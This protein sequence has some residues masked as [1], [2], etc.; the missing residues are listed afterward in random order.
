M[1]GS[2]HLGVS[3]SLT[4]RLTG[5]ANRGAHP[6]LKATVKVP[7][8]NAD[9]RRAVVTLPRSEILDQGHIGTTCTR[10][11][12]AAQACPA[13]SKYGFAKAK[14]PL[15]D[16][17]LE[18]PVYLRAS[19]HKLPD[20]VA[21]L[22]GQIRIALDGKIE[23]VNGAIRTIFETVPDAPITSFVLNMQGG[24]KGLLQNTTNIC[25]GVNR[26]KAKFSAQNGRQVSLNPP[27]KNTS[28]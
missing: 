5:K 7:K 18:G 9:I 11:Q 3:P 10:V 6:K 25:R 4:T 27:L 19:N 13:A 15:L 21:D 16:K 24:S 20:L 14:T 12:F 2:E 8:G 26:T 22:R 17:P 28:C 1:N 23:S